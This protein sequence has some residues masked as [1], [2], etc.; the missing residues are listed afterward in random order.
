MREKRYKIVK[1]LW[2]SGASIN[3]VSKHLA[4]ELGYVGVPEEKIWS[5]VNECKRV[6]T[7]EHVIDIIDRDGNIHNLLAYEAGKKDNREQGIV[8]GH[9]SMLTRQTKL[10]YASAFQIPIS[11]LSNAEGRIDLVIGMG[12]TKIHPKLVKELP[13]E[14]VQLFDTNFGPRRYLLGGKLEQSWKPEIKRPSCWF[15]ETNNKR[16]KTETITKH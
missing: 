4:A 5:T 16:K 12:N 14:E 3:L 2:D 8:S 9:G 7:M 13:N 10:K 15:H 11:Q 1:V 6:R